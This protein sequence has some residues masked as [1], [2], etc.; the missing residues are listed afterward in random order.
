MKSKI[1]G[2]QNKSRGL[3]ALPRQWWK[4]AV[5]LVVV[6]AVVFGALGREMMTAEATMAQAATTQTTPSATATA[7]TGSVVA[8]SLTD[9][10]GLLTASE[11]ASVL[12]RLNQVNQKYGVGIAVVTAKSLGGQQISNYANAL[13]DRYFY[14]GQNGNMVLVIDMGQ[15]HWYISTD[16]KMRQVVTDDYGYKKIGDAVAAQMKKKNY[17]A[18][19]TTYAQMTD[20]Y[21]A[22][23]K[24]EGRGRSSSDEFP[25]YPLLA[26]IVGSVLSFFG[27]RS[28]LI[29]SMS[30]VQ[31][32]RDASEYLRQGSFNL[33][34]QADN[35]IGTRVV[36]TPR[37]KSRSSGGHFS[38]SG[39]S[40]G[41]GGGSF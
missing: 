29:S 38:S 36:V 17:A 21:L 27:Y 2:A 28:S 11:K 8:A 14:R 19:F 12:S 15:R 4:R 26:G 41:G 33:T 32:A 3:L 37:A 1:V 30:N 40:H 9:G 31:V 20:E 25:L 39:G 34:G 23:Y 10:A 5:L 24:Q 22:F 6:L 35:F 13:L 7:Q 16:N 18:A